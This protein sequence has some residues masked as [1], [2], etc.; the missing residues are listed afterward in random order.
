MRRLLGIALTTLFLAS[1]VT[2]GFATGTVEPQGVGDE[3]VELLFYHFGEKPDGYEE[4]WGEI[5]E[6]LLERTNTTIRNNTIPWGD[7]RTK[8]NLLL[9]SGEEFDAV[10]A[11]EWLDYKQYAVNGHF[12]PLE[13][14]AAE[15][16]P[17]SWAQLPDAAIAQATV[18]GHVYMLPSMWVPQGEEGWVVRG[19]LREEYG[20]GPIET[21]EDLGE[22]LRAVKE[23][24]SGIIPFNA[25][26]VDIHRLPDHA[27]AF[28]DEGIALPAFFTYQADN[29]TD[30]Y[31][32]YMTDDYVEYCRTV[33]AW[34]D[35]GLIPAS[36]LANEN[37][38]FASFEN[39][40]SALALYGL[41]PMNESYVQI[42]TAHPD[43]ELEWYEPYPNTGSIRGT[44]TQ[45]GIVVPITSSKADRVMMVL[46]EFRQ[47]VDLY[48]LAAY[49]MRGTHWDLNDDGYMVPVPGNDQYSGFDISVWAWEMPS[50]KLLE[51]G[52]Y[53]DLKYW[54]ESMAERGYSDPL[55]MMVFDPEPIKNELAAINDILAEHAAP[56]NFG[57]VNDVDE[58]IAAFWNQM[59]LAGVELVIA[60]MESQIA[61]FL[62]TQ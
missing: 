51:P 57:L 55:S 7:Y 38:S 12:V 59:E 47:D 35:E 43:W 21:I 14:V 4:V 8:Y 52:G 45:Q 1:V 17:D 25:G 61:A 53:P 56:L 19:D 9:S 41:E 58:A 62:A 36:S 3:E 33:K 37:R 20:L 48:Q 22:Y 39:E 26:A 27:M 60:E 32:R 5:N 6:I 10:P 24:E 34:A 18:N 54:L 29:P 16:A 42:T 31:H 13:D 49:G 30:V 50:L 28:K 23:N 2:A 11:F 15:Y 40:Q 44:F 46:E